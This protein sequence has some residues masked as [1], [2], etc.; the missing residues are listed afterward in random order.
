ML[1]AWDRE[2]LY[3]GKLGCVA[4]P[5]DKHYG[6]VKHREWR[7]KVLRR[8][9]YLCQECERYGR[10]TLASHAHHVKPRDLYPE[11]TYV[12]ANGSALCPGCHSKIEPRVT[13]HLQKKL[14]RN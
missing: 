9:K 1:W 7:A 3:R 4:V 8:D 10:K 6:L 12:V 11:L 2:E 5:S 14:N 13:V